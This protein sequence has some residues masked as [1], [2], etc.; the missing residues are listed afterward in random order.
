M[1]N[2]FALAVLVA[3]TATAEVP[4][5]LVVDGVPEPSPALIERVAPYLDSRSAALYDWN[6]ERPEMLIGTRF[7]EAAQ[8]HVVK[9]PGGDRK[10]ITF[11]NEPVR[12]SYRPHH[13]D[14]I[15]FTKDRGGNEQF[16]LY[17]YDLA[18]GTTA[19][20]TDGK[21]R[22]LPNAWSRDGRWLSYGSN[23]RSAKDIDLWIVDPSDPAS[24][25]IVL[26]N[27][28]GGWFVTDFSRDGRKLL[29]GNF[30][31]ATDT[32]LYIVDAATGEKK[33]LTPKKQG[34]EVAYSG[35]AFS[36]DDSEI[37]FTTDEGSEFQQLIRMRLADGKRTVVAKEAWDVGDFELSEDRKLLAYAINENGADTLRLVDLTTGKALPTPTLPLGVINTFKWHPKTGLLGIALSS[38][39]SPS[40][41][42]SWDYRKKELVRWTESETGGLNP[43]RN[44]EPERVTIKSFDVTS[45]FALVYH[46]DA[47]K[48]PGKRPALIQ[49]HGGPEGQTR[50]G[51]IGRN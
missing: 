18:N 38:A 27:E 8:L 47:K 48:F 21:S 40:D 17:R 5:N 11:Y 37:F 46:P 28:G 12:G 39:K 41:A 14:T 29:V 9:M 24:A 26:Q 2:V 13:G 25:K 32:D 50:A 10:Q 22:N 6:P 23:K 16:Q 20:L 51:F 15:V 34:E 4:S 1:R 3:A 31:S 42:Y 19:M 7:G 30:H 35:A 36:S 49:I 43:E 45:I 33:L 44:A